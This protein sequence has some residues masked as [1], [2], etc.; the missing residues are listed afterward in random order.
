MEP[1]WRYF[2]RGRL[3]T[4]L[5]WPSSNTPPT[6]TT[7]YLG[8]PKRSHLIPRLPRLAAALRVATG[9]AVRR[10]V[11]FARSASLQAHSVGGTRRAVV[12]WT[13]ATPSDP[14][15]AQLISGLSIA[16]QVNSGT[17]S[18]PMR[19]RRAFPPLSRLTPA[20]PAPPDPHQQNPDRPGTRSTRSSR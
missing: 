2:L 14:V 4:I 12:E 6:F 13:R 3:A 18:V 7:P 11:I 17:T 19:A 16:E 10:G 5:D 8:T 20:R 1:A 15:I 9:R